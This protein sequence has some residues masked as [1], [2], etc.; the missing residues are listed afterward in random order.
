MKIVNLGSGSKGNSTVV[1]AESTTILIDAGLPINEIETKLKV[2]DID[3]K[4]IDAILITHEH[5]DHIK[6]VG[7]LSTKYNIPIYTHYLEVNCLLSKDKNILP[8]LIRTFDDNDFYIKDLTISNFKLSHDANLCVGYSIYSNG[9]KFSILTDLGHCP[10]NIVEKI[11]N[12]NVVLLEANHDE[13]L[14]LNNPKYPMILKKRILSNKG[15]LSNKQSAEVISQL[16]GGTSQIILGHLSEE[17]NSPSFAYSAIKTFL[18]EKGIIE[19]KH[20]FIDVA[21]QNKISNIFE[22]KNK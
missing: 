16:V 21:Y 3:I 14:L 22:I 1:C 17:N 2:I 4:D 5:S 19:G 13:N 18:A 9:A 20:I 12:S 15:H 8:K 7:R 6:N 11:K 10:K